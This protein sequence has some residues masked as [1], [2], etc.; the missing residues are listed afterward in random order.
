MIIARSPLRIT[1]GGGATDLP[2]YYSQF[3]GF[4]L[5]AAINKY[6]YISVHK[7]FWDR[8]NLKYSKM[9]DVQLVEEIEHPIFREALKRQGIES[10]IELSSMADIPAGT[11][12]G[13]SSAFCVALLKALY[14]YNKRHATPGNLAEEASHIEID[15]LHEP[16]G[17]QDQYAS[18]FGGINCLRFRRDGR[19]DVTSLN[20]ESDTL[21]S[22]EDRLL[23]F[24]TGYQR[25]ASK[26]L[27][28]QKNQTLR[29]DSEMIENLHV[30]KQIGVKAKE[31]LERGDLDEF[32]EMMN[33]HWRFKKKRS[34]SMSNEKIDRCYEKAMKNGAVGGKLIGAGGGGFLMF[35]AQ[36]TE[37]LRS[38]MAQEGLNEVE[39][40]FDFEGAK[41]LVNET[42]LK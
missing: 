24:F 29:N 19:V 31:A 36:D 9:E 34:K 22:L 14:A 20:I 40:T 39:F 23:L 30:V 11:G 35:L 2:S 15:L 3:E 10:R 33:E 12:L 13:S 5:N 4:V 38:V 32:A 27:T 8:I 16:I 1:L 25:A 18:A 28:E 37:K 7:L 26:V 42:N 21:Y 41:V 6:V 17:K